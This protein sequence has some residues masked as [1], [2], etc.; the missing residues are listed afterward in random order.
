M[1]TPDSAASFHFKFHSSPISQEGVAN[2]GSYTIAPPAYRNRYNWNMHDVR[3]GFI[4]I[5]L[6][7]PVTYAGL[8]VS[9]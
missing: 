4:Q 5:N 6:T 8:T 9:P 3:F 2:S 1:D 7:N